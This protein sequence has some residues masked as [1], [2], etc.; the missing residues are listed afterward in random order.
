MLVAM[1][2]VIISAGLQDQKF[3][4]TYTVGFPEFQDICHGKRRQHAQ[5]A[6]LG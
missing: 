5:N 1:A 2:Q 6:A 3:I 4:D